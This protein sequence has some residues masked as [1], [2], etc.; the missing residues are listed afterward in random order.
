MST[1]IRVVLADDHSLIR[2]GIKSVLQFED[3]IDIVGE[4]VNGE[5]AL[6][7]VKTLLPDILIM[8]IN[9]PIMS[10][11]E[12]LKEIQE[13]DIKVHVI[14]LTI[15]NDRELLMEALN[16]GANGYLLK[17]SNP[18]DLIRGINEINEGEN[19]IDN[20]LLK[21]LVRGYA[22]SKREDDNLL[23]RLSRRELEVL[24]LMSEGL[25][26]KE[27]GD[28]L[29]LSEKTVKNYAYNMFKKLEVKDRVQA[30]I[31]AL[32]NNLKDYI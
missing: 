26:N 5:E 29:F 9:M 21:Y 8:D 7:L 15:S 1:K 31:Y 13:S 3:N 11:I 6:N 30:T 24:N 2:K 27:I 20:R 19:F 23:S 16:Y 10:G 4:G 25:S 32:K 28:K 14:L 22:S 17:D 18:D 12:V